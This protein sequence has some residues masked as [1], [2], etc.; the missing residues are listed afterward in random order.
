MGEE[1]KTQ[2]ILKATKPGPSQG[3]EGL[4][5]RLSNSHAF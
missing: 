3:K 5:E 2:R 4:P 1:G